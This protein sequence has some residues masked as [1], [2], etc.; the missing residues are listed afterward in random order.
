MDEQ[1]AA[2]VYPFA[3]LEPWPFPP[4]ATHV[5]TQST[6]TSGDGGGVHSS[7]GGSGAGGNKAPSAS[8]T[9]LLLPHVHGT[10]GFFI[11]RWRFR[12]QS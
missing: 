8:H 1:A 4:E 6:N 7:D 2:G 12:K 5:H 3:G 10:D 9:R 11:A